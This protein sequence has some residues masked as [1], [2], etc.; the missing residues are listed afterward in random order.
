MRATDLVCVTMALLAGVAAEAQAPKF[1]TLDQLEAQKT[2][3]E[4][5][6]RRFWLLPGT[7]VDA[8]H[9]GFA[10]DPKNVDQENVLRY[11]AEKIA[12]NVVELVDTYV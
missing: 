6:G 4:N 3:D 7:S 2:K 10:D 1:K 12:F 11:P 9:F 5:V 8:F